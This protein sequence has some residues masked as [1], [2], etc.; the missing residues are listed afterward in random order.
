MEKNVSSDI[1]SK[2]CLPSDL[3]PPY[4]A[5][6]HPSAEASER[7]RPSESPD[8]ILQKKAPPPTKNSFSR[9]K[10]SFNGKKE[11][12]PNS[13]SFK[14]EHGANYGTTIWLKSPAGGVQKKG[15]HTSRQNKSLK[16]WGIFD[17]SS[18]LS[19]CVLDFFGICNWINN[20]ISTTEVKPRN[21]KTLYWALNFKH[22][23][24]DVWSP[25]GFYFLF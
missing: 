24:C 3:P 1:L 17:K 11:S 8:M 23:P 20:E 5:V 22:L 9:P 21:S 15:R 13:N 18:V 10:G 14:N 6:S 25:G 2:V 19:F 12:L 4:D 16:S 7:D